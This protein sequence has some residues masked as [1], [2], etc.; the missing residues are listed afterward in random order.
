MDENTLSNYLLGGTALISRI[1]KLKGM[2]KY[3]YFQSSINCNFTAKKA[4]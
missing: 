1:L 3:F 4:R 2:L